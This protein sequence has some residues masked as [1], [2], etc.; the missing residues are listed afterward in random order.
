MF[1]NESKPTNRMELRDRKSL[2]QISDPHPLDLVSG[3]RQPKGE[4]EMQRRSSCA[5][6]KPI[7][8]Q[9]VF[10]YR[11]WILRFPHYNDQAIQG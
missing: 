3:L 10:M 6:V 11:N 5:C 2:C 9:P 7:Y 1:F 4:N 8:Q